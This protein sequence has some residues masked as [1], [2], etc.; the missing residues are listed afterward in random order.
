MN[1]VMDM[2][3]YF[4]KVKKF[5]PGGVHYNFNLPWEEKPI[6]YKDTN[7]SRVIDLEGKEFLDLYAR[8]GAMILG[9]NNREYIDAVK[10]AMDHVF[11]VSHSYYDYEVLEK[12]N[13][14]VPSAE[15]IRFGLAGTEVVQ[16]ALRLSRAYTGRDKFIRFLNHYHGNSDNIMGGKPSKKNSMPREFKGDYKGTLGREEGA[17]NHS[18]LLPWNDIETLEAFLVEHYNEIAAII[19]E[20][21][22]VN[23]G[24]IMPADGYLQSLRDLCDK[25]GIVLI[26]DEIITGIRTGLGCAQSLFG[27]TPD[28]TL[29]G[30][31]L[32][33]GGIPVSA[34]VGKEKIMSLYT[35]KNVIHA[36]TFNGYP[37]GMAAVNVTL[38]ILGR[39]NSS[40]LKKMNETVKKIHKIIKE[41]ADRVGIPMVIQGYPSCAAYHCCENELTTP[42]E[43]NYDITT[44]DVIINA[45]LQRNGVLIS[46]VSR[47]YPNISL[48]D[49][50]V[51][52][53][54]KRSKK[55]F[56]E[57]AP[58][59]NK[60]IGK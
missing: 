14:Y 58:V 10:E 26:F 39:D 11:S 24:S 9:H 37:A 38:D 20:P 22:C 13:K 29:L 4:E 55:A 21:I 41:Q 3:T 49:D 42:S 5:L 44:R 52:W 57:A 35:S 34:I 17:F 43:Y 31:A 59:I 18:Y 50:D 1:M 48:S 12:I 27:V 47:I 45:Y 16:N 32:A 36:G 28:L 60:I 54:E 23:G 6:F 15:M 19:T 7:G 53:F 8:F 25:Y 56:N 51:D 2:D 30:K 33:G 46:S 40:S